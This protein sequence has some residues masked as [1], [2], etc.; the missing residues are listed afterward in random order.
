MSSAPSFSQQS[1]YNNRDHGAGSSTGSSS[2]PTTEPVLLII[3][4]SLLESATLMLLTLK[5]LSLLRMNSWLSAVEF[6]VHNDLS[7][8]S[9]FCL[10][11]P[12]DRCKRLLPACSSGREPGKSFGVPEEW[13]RHQYLQSGKFT[14]LRTREIPP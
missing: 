5:D 4:S 1:V 6:V 11:L 10:R 3:L 13:S 14:K 8:P 2:T 7:N 12:A 9:R